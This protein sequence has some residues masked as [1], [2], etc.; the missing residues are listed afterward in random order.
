MENTRGHLFEQ[1]MNRL[2]IAA[3]ADFETLVVTAA[4]EEQIY[5]S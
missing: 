3:L 5:H 4:L 1:S 2:R